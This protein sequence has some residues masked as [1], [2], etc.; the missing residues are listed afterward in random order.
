M[1]LLVVAIG[2]LGLLIGSFLNVVIHRVPAG[3]SV[4]HPRSRCPQC[5]TE[6][7]ARDNVPVVSWLL[8]RGKCRTCGAPISVRYPLVELGT[9]LLFAAVAWWCGATWALPAYLYLAAISVALSAIDLDVR[10]L[11]NVIVLP[12][13]VVTLALLL[14]PAIVEGRWA[15]FRTAVLTGVG[16]YA[17][18]FLL[19]FIYPAGMGWGDVK[20][21]GVLG[22][23]LGWVSW[24]LAILATFVAFIVGALVGLLVMVRSGEGRKTKVPFG[25]FMV[26]GTW[27]A[28][29]WGQPVI[30]WYVG[31]LGG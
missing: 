26:I 10:R 9:G 22:L 23:Y 27:T 5:G 25:P 30:D 19:A 4:V 1:V 11:P 8:L 6:L 3:E 2:V 12:S 17:F 20:L 15:D 31:S 24:Q 28:L 16:L 7:A 13:Y 18:Y 14:V 29:F 21:A